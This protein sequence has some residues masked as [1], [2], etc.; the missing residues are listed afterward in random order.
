VE[1]RVAAGAAFSLGGAS[2]TAPAGSMALDIRLAR[3]WA[4]GLRA[5]VEGSSATAGLPGE[6]RLRHVPLAVVGDLT[7]LRA[8][9]VS[10][11]VAAGPLLEVVLASG[12]KYRTVQTRTLWEPGLLLAPRVEW[13]AWRGLGLFAEAGAMVLLR[14]DE[15][16]VANVGVVGRTPR[17]RLSCAAGAAWRI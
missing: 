12:V 11:S 14:T 3:R 15:L 7:L 10:L 16:A 5:G 2:S 1:L 9:R 6:V 13:R 8:R 17:W 4:V